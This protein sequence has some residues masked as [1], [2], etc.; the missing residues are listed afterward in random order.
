MPP[1]AVTETNMDSIAKLSHAEPLWFQAF[2]SLLASSSFRHQLAQR[3]SMLESSGRR[4]NPSMGLGS[5]ILPPTL[6]EDSNIERRFRHSPPF[7]VRIMLQG[8]SRVCGPSLAGALAAG[9]AA[10]PTGMCL[11]AS[12][13]RGER[14]KR[15]TRSAMRLPEKGD[16]PQTRRFNQRETEPANQSKGAI[17]SATILTILISGLMA[18][19]AVSL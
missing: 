7:V 10:E 19:P 11:L 9:A 18:G 1:S 17:S 16:G 5:G 13:A 12:P 3:L 6:P 15:R 8:T 4:M 2:I 14:A